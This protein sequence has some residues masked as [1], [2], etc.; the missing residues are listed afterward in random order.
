[1]E[2]VIIENV[3]LSSMGNSGWNYSVLLNGVRVLLG[4]SVVF[5][6]PHDQVGRMMVEYTDCI[7]LKI[8]WMATMGGST[9]AYIHIEKDGSLILSNSAEPLG[10]T[11]DSQLQ[12]YLTID[13]CP[14]LQ[15]PSRN[16][17]INS[18]EFKLNRKSD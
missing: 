2:K 8:Q 11:I 5:D 9:P 4:A 17:L 6:S 1:M 14:P 13:M 18:F 10:D 16:E 7:I 15:S 3:K 12:E